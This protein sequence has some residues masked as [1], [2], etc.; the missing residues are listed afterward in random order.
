[1]ATGHG[2]NTNDRPL[3]FKRR[4]AG[5]SG[6]AKLRT[7]ARMV[8]SST[9]GRLKLGL[10]SICFYPLTPCLNYAH[11]RTSNP[12]STTTPQPERQ[13]N[14][15]TRFVRL[16]LSQPDLQGIITSPSRPR[17]SVLPIGFHWLHTVRRLQ[18]RKDIRPR[19]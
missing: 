10:E 17:W 9:I 11:V 4:L 5:S 19:L 6:S 3:P 1:M 12:D 16:H 15:N 8:D 7:I 14:K 18:G 13:R 2:G